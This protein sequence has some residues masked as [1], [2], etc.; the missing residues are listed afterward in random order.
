MGAATASSAVG[1]AALLSYGAKLLR[2][3]CQG[4]GRPMGVI[5]KHKS[6]VW[7]KP[8]PGNLARGRV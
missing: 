8:I 2:V 3:R 6:H 1:E 7:V 4:C 5:S